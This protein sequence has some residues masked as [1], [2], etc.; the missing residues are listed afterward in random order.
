M[1][2]V[3]DGMIG[4]KVISP[5]ST[6][7]YFFLNFLVVLCLFLAPMTLIILSETLTFSCF[8]ALSLTSAVHGQKMQLCTDYQ[9]MCR[10]YTSRFNLPELLTDSSGGGLIIS[11]MFEI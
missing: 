2:F 1:F 9:G 11:N 3:P 10:L 5:C 6:A 7:S 4:C 8:G